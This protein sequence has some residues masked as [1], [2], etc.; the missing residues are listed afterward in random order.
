[1]KITMQTAVG[2]C[3]LSI[4][5]VL[6]AVAS[7]NAI[8]APPGKTARVCDCGRPSTNEVAC[9][10]GTTCEAQDTRAKCESTTTQFYHIFNFPQTCVA[11]EETLTMCNKPN[12]DCWCPI[13]CFYGEQQTPRCYSN[14]NWQSAVHTGMPKPI[15][16]D[17]PAGTTEC[18]K[19]IK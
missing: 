11:I 4:G 19:L 1:M 17:C 10:N 8:A 13:T 2:L 6:L 9:T 5:T 7:Q 3:A 15:S 14:P 18:S 16:E 12:A